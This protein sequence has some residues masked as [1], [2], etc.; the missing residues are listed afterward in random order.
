MDVTETAVGF[1]PS[2]SPD[3]LA[4]TSLGLFKSILKIL[5]S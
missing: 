4:L 3:K 5:F 1:N 2:T